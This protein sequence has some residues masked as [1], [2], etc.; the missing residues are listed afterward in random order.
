ME[1]ITIGQIAL[2]VTFLVGLIG[3]LGYLKTHLKEWVGQS[4]KDQFVQMDSKIEQINRRLDNVDLENCKNF[5]VTVITEVEK[6]GWLHEVERERFWE[7]YEHYVKLG[8]NSYIKKKVE[9][10]EQDGKL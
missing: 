4:V 2:A 3:G 6:G 8:G 1:N 10:L 7:E 5:L 9:Q